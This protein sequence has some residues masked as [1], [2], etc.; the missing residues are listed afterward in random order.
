MTFRYSSRNE[1]ADRINVILLDPISQSNTLFI[2]EFV[3]SKVANISK[4]N[5]VI[6]KRNKEINT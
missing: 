3:H 6:N 5:E 2:F 1:T 4:E